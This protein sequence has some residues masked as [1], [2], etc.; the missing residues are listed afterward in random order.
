MQSFFGLTSS[1]ERMSPHC[2]DRFSF[3]KILNSLQASGSVVV[4]IG[5]QPVTIKIRVLRFFIVEYHHGK[6]RSAMS[7]DGK[8]AKDAAWQ[9]YIAL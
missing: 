5:S 6:L 9:P 1:L 4:K 2:R 8:R 3:S 7:L